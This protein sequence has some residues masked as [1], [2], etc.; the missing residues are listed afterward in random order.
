MLFISILKITKLAIFFE[1]FIGGCFPNKKRH[2][3]EEA[4]EYNQIYIDGKRIFRYILSCRYCR[5]HLARHE[6]LVSKGF[7]GS[8]G[9]AY[10]FDEVVN[11]ASGQAE[12]RVLLTG[13][14]HV[15]D[16]FCRSCNTV[17]GWKYEHAFEPAQKYKEGKT[18]IE[19]VHMFKAGLRIS[20]IFRLRKRSEC[21]FIQNFSA[22]RSESEISFFCAKRSEN[23]SKIANKSEILS[24]AL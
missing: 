8:Q 11:V 18:I 3:E 7:Q 13:R 15:A 21:E 16:V 22:K 12:E 4:W 17:L 2:Q 6:S 14:H 23:F 20:H 9:R 10:L 5:A 24:E 19:L 1:S